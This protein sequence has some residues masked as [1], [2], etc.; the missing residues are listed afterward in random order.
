MPG[1]VIDRYGPVAVVRVDGE[2]ANAR[3]PLVLEVARGELA[4]RGID[5]VLLR[6]TLEKPEVHVLHGTAPTGLL[7]VAEEGVPLLVDVLRGQK[8]GAFLDQRENRRRVGA[9]ARGLRVL[10]LCSYTGG[11]SLHAALGGATEVTSVD[12]AMAAHATAEQNFRAAGVDPKHHRFVTQD[13]FEYLAQ[14]K[15]ARETFDLV[16]SDPP[17]FARNERSVPKALAS[18]RRLHEACASVLASGGV[19]CA[20]S[21]SSHVRTEDFLA[22]L[23]DASLK[24]SGLRLQEIY[25]LPGD[26]PT[27]PAWPEGRYLKFAVLS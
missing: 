23:D 13:A 16:I 9:M 10:N 22:T 4:T 25:G 6:S 12:I 21:C 24:T 11:F 27:L 2:A 3:L 17:S 26:H 15:R 18:Y 1:Y 7:E 19:F 14:A 5:T 20:S 8:T